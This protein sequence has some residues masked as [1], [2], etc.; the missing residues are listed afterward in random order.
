MSAV[1]NF[2]EVSRSS[3]SAPIGFDRSRYV[4]VESRSGRRK[5]SCATVVNNPQISTQYQQYQRTQLL[6][7]VVRDDPG[8][9]W[10]LRE[11]VEAAV[12]GA[13]E[14]DEVVK[15]GDEAVLP[16]EGHVV[17]AD[18]LEVQKR[19]RDDSDTKLIRSLKL[20]NVWVFV[21]LILVI[22]R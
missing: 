11:I 21:Q 15:V 1:R 8:E 17:L 3:S 18:V 9:D 22:D 2:S 4:E 16:L 6:A 10:I 13:V 12:G 7:D 5:L 19:L 20:G 14:V